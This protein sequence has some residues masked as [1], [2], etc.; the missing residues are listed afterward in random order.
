M[1]AHQNPK[2]P[3]NQICLLIKLILLNLKVKMEAEKVCEQLKYI[4]ASGST[5]GTEER[6]QLDC[7]LHNLQS[8]MRFETLYFWGKING[9]C[10]NWIA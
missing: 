2:T 5:L 1:C 4:Q 9:K 3:F 8:S 6:M 10:G 7:A